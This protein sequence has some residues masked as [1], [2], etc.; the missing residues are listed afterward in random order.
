MGVRRIQISP[1]LITTVLRVGFVPWTD[2]LEPV[3]EAEVLDV[4]PRGNPRCLELLIESPTFDGPGSEG[5]WPA[6]AEGRWDEFPVFLPTFRVVPDRILFDP[7][8]D[9]DDRHGEVEG[10]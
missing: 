5:R 2:A 9:P 6:I 1:A 4:R 3:Q 7:P 10:T 8:D